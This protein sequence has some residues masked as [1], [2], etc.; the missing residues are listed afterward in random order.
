MDDILCKDNVVESLWN[1][2]KKTYEYKKKG[3]I[4]GIPAHHSFVEKQETLGLKRVYEN[5]VNGSI[6]TIQKRVEDKDVDGWL[7]EWKKMQD[8]LFQYVLK[9]RGHWRKKDVRIGD[10]YDETLI[11]PNYLLVPGKIKFLANYINSLL[12]ENNFTKEDKLN[13]LADIHFRFI[14]IHPFD[15][16]NGRIARAITDQV[17]LYFGL[18]PAIVGYPRHNVKQQLAY[19]KAIYMC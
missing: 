8:M 10:P 15:D 9:S 3:L 19:H 1:G 17:S 11:L 14:M 7:D 4:E 6:N 12:M 2:Y 13:I 5:Y 18:P 16:G